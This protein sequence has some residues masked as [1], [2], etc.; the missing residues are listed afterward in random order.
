MS[1]GSV[2]IAHIVDLTFVGYV[3]PA[4]SLITYFKERQILSSMSA[5]AVD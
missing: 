1:H 3:L 5:S 2:Y 4:A